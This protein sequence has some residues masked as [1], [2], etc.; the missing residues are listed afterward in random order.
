MIFSFMRSREPGQYGLASSPSA[1][2]A[3]GATGSF[4]KLPGVSGLLN[5]DGGV[6]RNQVRLSFSSNCKP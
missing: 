4:S 1:P 6:V 3:S 2:S 5:S